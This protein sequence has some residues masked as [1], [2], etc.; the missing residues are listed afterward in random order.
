MT[1]V[2]HTV[3]WYFAV[4]SLLNLSFNIPYYLKGF[5]IS[6]NDETYLDSSIYEGFQSSVADSTSALIVNIKT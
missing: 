4:Q 6:R 5:C 3:D 1:C 2:I